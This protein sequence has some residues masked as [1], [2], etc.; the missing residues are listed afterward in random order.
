[1]LDEDDDGKQHFNLKS[2]IENENM[3]KSKRKRQEKQ[4][5]KLGKEG[6]DNTASA[7]QD[8]FEIDTADPRFEA[9]FTSHEYSIDPSAPQYKQTKAMSTLIQEKQTRRRKK[10]ERGDGDGRDAKTDAEGKKMGKKQDVELSQLVKSI[11]NK[12]EQFH[13]RKKLKVDS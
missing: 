2:I 12:T 9:L 11:K 1:M 7:G 13:S 10:E 6:D 3:S 8:N 4:Q 5:R